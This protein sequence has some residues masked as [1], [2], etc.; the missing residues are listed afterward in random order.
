MDVSIKGA[1][2]LSAGYTVVLLSSAVTIKT[3]ASM[4]SQIKMVCFPMARHILLFPYMTVSVP[5]Y[6]LKTKIDRVA[7]LS[8]SNL[9]A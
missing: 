8:S 5:E 6:F 4:F 2:I 1:C 9:N 3:F 7:T